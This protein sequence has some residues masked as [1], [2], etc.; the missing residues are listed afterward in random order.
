MLRLTTSHSS[1]TLA[2]W[3]LGVSQ[4]IGYGTLYYSFSILTADIGGSLGVSGAWLYGSLSVGLLASG[5][6]APL[7]GRAIDHRGA[8][9]IMAAGS[10]LAALALAG[11]SLAGNFPALA[12]GIVTI[13]LT[14]GL[15]LYDAAFAALTQIAGTEARQRITH[16]TLIAGFASTLFWPLTDWLQGALGW[17]ATLLCY[18]ALNLLV[19]LPI[20]L[21]LAKRQVRGHSATP[22]RPNDAAVVRTDSPLPQPWRHRVLILVALSFA[23]SGFALS[24]VLAQMVPLLTSM[25]FGGS[26]LI[27]STVFGPAQVLIRFTNMLLGPRRHPLTVALIALSILPVALVVLMATAPNIAGA[28]LFAALLGCSSGLKSIVQGTVPLALFGSA[29]YGARL[30]VMALA[31]QVLAAAAPV[32]LSL[33]AGPA[34]PTYALAALAVVACLAVAALTSVWRIED[35]RRRGLLIPPA[36]AQQ[37]A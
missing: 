24:A 35:L 31:R 3:L 19:C 15:V 18:A 20:H 2:V 36:E 13:Q 10:L 16:L 21:L 7:V 28:V 37:L 5:L 33:L 9:P 34:G 27:V 8:A 30:G 14:S 22:A 11:A 29:S 26:A 23:L 4:I 12:V 6:V 1:L 25:G 32:A 17:R